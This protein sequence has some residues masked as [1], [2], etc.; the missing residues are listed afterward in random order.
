MRALHAR[1]HHP[2]GFRAHVRVQEVLS[3]RRLGYQLMYLYKASFA[4]KS[5]VLKNIFRGN[6]DYQKKFLQQPLSSSQNLR[7]LVDTVKENAIFVYEFS[8]S[9]SFTFPGDRSRVRQENSIVKRSLESLAELHDRGIIHTNIKPNHILI[10]NIDYEQATRSRNRDLTITQARMS[11]LE[12]AVLL[13]LTDASRVASP[14]T[15]SSFAIVAIYIMLNHM[16]FL[17]SNQEL[18]TDRAWAHVL[19]K[20]IMYLGTK[21]GFTGLMKH[22]SKEN[23]FCE[24][25]LSL[26]A[27]FGDGNSGRP[28][29][30]RD[31]RIS[32]SR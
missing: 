27:E 12:D 1:D 30:T 29:A 4:Q 17:E 3:E 19:R 26:A 24:R 10:D 31:F 16:L 15:G 18:K 21:D 23:P 2:R 5:F 13:A 25:L 8:P 28:F 32:F 6:Y 20:H 7:A 11:D 22:T 14:E 9:I